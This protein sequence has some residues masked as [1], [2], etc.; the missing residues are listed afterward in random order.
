MLAASSKGMYLSIAKVTQDTRV[1]S[2]HVGFQR[3]ACIL[4]INRMLQ[5]SVSNAKQRHMST[6]Q[7]FVRALLLATLVNVCLPG[8]RTHVGGPALMLI[9][10]LG[11]TAMNART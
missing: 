1:G 10:M 7:P 9:S 4:Y 8:R 5:M 11:L 6:T 2:N 3:V